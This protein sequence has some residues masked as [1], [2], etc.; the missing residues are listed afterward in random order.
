MKVKMTMSLLF[1]CLNLS[2]QEVGPNLYQFQ[3]NLEEKL[4]TL[5]NQIW[6]LS[7]ANSRLDYREQKSSLLGTINEM[8]FELND[9]TQAVRGMRYFG[10][11]PHP[12]VHNPA[13]PVYPRYEAPIGT[14][15]TLNLGMVRH[16][17]GKAYQTRTNR[18]T[19]PYGDS[20]SAPTS[21][22]MRLYE[23]K[24]NGESLLLGK[25]HSLHAD[26]RRIGAGRFS[27][28][29]RS[30]YFSSSDGSSVFN[31]GYSYIYCF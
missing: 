20:P 11:Q 22:Q 13:T 12:P 16:E 5:S 23:V 8:V 31:N 3:Q 4:E 10:H 15:Y 19:L 29:N 18:M 9:L 21:S 6:N 26:I 1:L 25:P 27:H 14:C 24:P 17:N 30:L 7:Q 2:A 28:W